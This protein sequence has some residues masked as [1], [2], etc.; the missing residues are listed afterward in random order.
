MATLGIYLTIAIVLFCI[1]M[2]GLASKR[3]AMRIL[4]S[5]EI[6]MNAANLS[7]VAFSRFHLPSPLA[8]QSIVLFTIA[9][10]AAEAAVGLAILILVSRVHRTIDVGEV[11]KLKG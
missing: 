7:L 11:R 8:G 2:Y 4:F 6:M 3:N 9:F 5:A 10:A 1:G